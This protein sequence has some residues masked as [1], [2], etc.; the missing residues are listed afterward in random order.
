MSNLVGRVHFNS[1]IDGKN[2]PKDAERI[3]RRAGKAGA[4]GFDKEWEKGFSKTLDKS[5]KASF[6][7]WR[8]SGRRD[9]NIYTS[10]FRRGLQ[11]FRRD[12]LRTFEGVR[13]GDQDFFDRMVKQFGSAEDAAKHLK[14]QLDSLR[15]SYDNRSINAASERLQRLTENHRRAAEATRLHGV[16]QE[17]VKE[18]ELRRAAALD[19]MNRRFRETVQMHTQNQ[20]TWDEYVR[21]VG[22]SEEAT[23]RANDELERRRDLLG[24]TDREHVRQRAAILRLS[25]A[26]DR[27][28]RSTRTTVV[29]NRSLSRI[30]PRTTQQ[31]SGMQRMIDKIGGSLKNFGNRGDLTPRTIA[32]IIGT[33]GEAIATLGSGLAAGITA[34]ISSIGVAIGGLAVM[35]GPALAGLVFTIGHAVSAL[36]LMGEEFPAAKAGMDELAKAAKNDSRAFARAWG[37]ALEEFTTRL[38]Q[39][40]RDDLMGERAG[41]AMAGITRA[42]TRVLESDGYKRFEEAMETSIPASIEN[43]GSGLA[44]VTEGLLNVFAAASPY[45]LELSTRFLSWA[46]EWAE[47]VDGIGE[48][49]G[50]KKFM[51]TALESISAVMGFTDSLGELLGTIFL[52]GAESG[53][54]LLGSIENAF[55]EWND[56]LNTIEGQNALEEWF[57]NGEIVMDAVGGLLVDVSKMFARLVTPETIDRLVNFLDLIG[58]AMDF[59]ADIMEVFGELDILG[60]VALL[61]ERVGNALGP[62][63]DMLEPIASIINSA[64][65]W[66]INNLANAISFLQVFMLPMQIAWE[67]LAALFERFVEFVAPI[68]DAFREVGDALHEATSAIMD[69]LRPAIE[70]IADS[71]FEMLPSPQEFARFLREE[72]IPRIQDL[73]NWIINNVV[74]AVEKFADW[75]RDYGIPAAEAFW[76]FIA[77]TLIP[78]FSGLWD[79]LQEAG[80]G[81]TRFKDTV[82]GAINVLTSPIR[83]LI[84]LFNKM[85]GAADGANGASSRAGGGGGRLQAMASGGMLFGPTRI[86][87]GEAGPEAIVPLRRPLSQVD[88]DVRWLSAIAQGKHTP[89]ANG[90]VVGAS[91][92][93]VNVEAGAIV[94]QATSSPIATSVA[95]LDR[96]AENLN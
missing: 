36:E 51:D 32:I 45:L 30:L 20:A 67:F 21:T 2:M 43:L 58:G 15:G 59:F 11:N 12:A 91:G 13:F 38:A 8:K 73:T 40:W 25:A 57:R 62:I 35:A 74:P 34:I 18:I 48:S 31:L 26:H 44:S 90:G 87:A 85:K 71:I 65:V 81:F 19:E 69:A 88:P 33:L 60:L 54:R 49:E 41:E 17:K 37:P 27:A 4:D 78:M 83:G 86:L 46:D 96:I 53:N 92:R 47:K 89:M 79:G 82:I 1:T 61:L 55:R 93:T 72:L 28:S 23:R 52:K 7:R 9:S 50:F 14:I 77:N 75:L 56:W 6:D 63:L 3:G 10:I 84:D 70:E 24:D 76:D 39:L 64:L 5:A 22:S 29:T 68:Q 80:R 94:V 16:E 66:G 42:F 95:V